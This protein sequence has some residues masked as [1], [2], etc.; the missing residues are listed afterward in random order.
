VREREEE[1]GEKKVKQSQTERE[2]CNKERR[3]K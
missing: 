2:K 3:G 1:G